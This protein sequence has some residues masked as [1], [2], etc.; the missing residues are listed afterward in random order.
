MLL[1][2][3]PKTVPVLVH[4]YM[5]QIAEDGEICTSVTFIFTLRQKYTNLEILA[6]WIRVMYKTGLGSRGRIC[7]E[8]TLGPQGGPPGGPKV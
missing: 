2:E 5:G 7:P 6:R 8:K 3:S 1:N 4:S